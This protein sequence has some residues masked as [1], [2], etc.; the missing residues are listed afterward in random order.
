MS[1]P[2]TFSSGSVA[3]SPALGRTRVLVLRVLYALLS[4]WALVM[5]SFGT[6]VVALHRLPD[7]ALTFAAL[8]AGAFKILTLGPALVVLASRGRSV[9][10]V[11]VLVVG[12]LVWLVTDLLAP[13]DGASV[14][15]LMARYVVSTVLWVGPWLALSPGRSRLWRAPL[16]VRPVVLGLAAVVSAACLPWA[17]AGTRLD[18]SQTT[19]V[20]TMA[21]LRY[22]VVGLAL[23]PLA[24][25]FVAAVVDAPWWD[26]WV[27]GALVWL[28]MACVVSPHGYGS[29]GYVGVLGVV[30][31]AVL[32][33]V[34]FRRPRHQ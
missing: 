33:W 21:E 7:P 27:A 1:T 25:L 14:P 22:D 29:P 24:A 12:Q 3:T 6:V 30:P 15:E 2:L 17:L 26:R 28:A 32:V 34:S 13:Q 5:S 9:L 20:G 8:G 19:S 4:L 16:S 10:A 18:A 23:A 11:R 31:A